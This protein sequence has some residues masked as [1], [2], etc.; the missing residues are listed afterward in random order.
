MGPW[1]ALIG[2]RLELRCANRTH[3]RSPV[4]LAYPL[5][6]D[7]GRCFYKIH[8]P[9]K[10]EALTRDR[11]ASLWY[12]CESSRPGGNPKG[13]K[14]GSLVYTWALRGC[15]IVTLGS[16]YGTLYLPREN[17]DKMVYGMVQAPRRKASYS[18]P[19]C[20]VGAPSEERSLNFATH[21]LCYCPFLGV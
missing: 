16:T 20:T 2:P 8:P 13:C 15:H 17:C 14:C 3:T 21:L 9:V 5:E 1:P 10:C 18:H 19:G 4:I 12:I 7:L 11:D 6:R